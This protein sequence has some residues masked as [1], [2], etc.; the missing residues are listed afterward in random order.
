LRISITHLHAAGLNA[1]QILKIVKEAEAERREKRRIIKR[2][3][4]ARPLDMVDNRNTVIN[5]GI[6]KQNQR[7]RPPCPVDKVDNGGHD[8]SITKR[9]PKQFE[10]SAA[11]EAFWQHYPL[12]VAKGAAHKAWERAIKSGQVT[13]E[14]LIAG[15]GRY[16]ADP[17]RD[18][19]YTKHGAT[20]LNAGCH[21]DSPLPPR[22]GQNGGRPAPKDD[23]RS[24]RGAFDRLFDQFNGRD[25]TGDVPRQTDL[26][27]VSGR[28]GE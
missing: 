11:F 28:S 7:A 17:N 19:S 9:E 22:G 6:I 27:V 12:H 21:N 14:E 13:N 3:Q 8:R 5:N 2:N 4:R 25:E 15:A 1:E 18:P 24:I 23:P 26:R 20:W 16:A 10:Y